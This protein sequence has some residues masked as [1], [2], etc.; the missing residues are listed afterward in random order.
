MASIPYKNLDPEKREIRLLE[1]V[2]EP[3]NTQI[4]YRLHTVSLDDKPYFTALSYVWGDPLVTEN[5]NIDGFQTPVTVN[6]ATALKHV[7]KHWLDI[8]NERDTGRDAVEFRIWAD[9]ICINQLDLPEKSKQVPLMKDIYAQADFIF[10]WLS[11]EDREISVSLEMLEIV[12]SF[13]KL[14]V[15]INSGQ[16]LDIADNDWAKTTHTLNHSIN[17][18]EMV[19]LV[20]TRFGYPSIEE[21]DIFP[22]SSCWTALKK[23]ADLSY[24]SR[25]WILQ[26]LMLPKSLYFVCPS[27]SL[28]HCNAIVAVTGIMETLGAIQR[29]ET[30]EVGALGRSRASVI[31]SKLFL[32][33]WRLNLRQAIHLRGYED[34][35]LYHVL[36][37][38]LFGTI[39]ATNPRDYVYGVL[40]ITNFDIT[41]DY[42]ASIRKV[43]LDYATKLINCWSTLW[44]PP[45][46][47]SG[48][49]FFLSLCA[50][51]VQR[52]G[53]LPTWVPAFNDLRPKGWFMNIRTSS[54]L[55][56]RGVAELCQA[57][58]VRISDASLRVAGVKAQK[59][60]YQY[61]KPLAAD[62]WTKDLLDCFETLLAARSST[63]ITG[64]PLLTVICCTLLQRLACEYNLRR[65]ASLFLYFYKWTPSGKMGEEFRQVMEGLEEM[66]MRDNM[67][68]M[69]SE[70]TPIM[71]ENA[72]CR[73]VGTDDYIG[74]AGGDVQNGD[75]V[76]VLK[77]C[78]SPVVLRPEED[79]YLF[80][81][82]CFMLG[83]MKG[84]VSEM[85]RSKMAE[86]EILEIR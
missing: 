42:H 57:S 7:K 77:D 52:N 62:F 8:Q 15:Y 21:R 2:C 35:C 27:R 80:V 47:T 84:E 28:D 22:P 56:F 23:L 16:Q 76:C 5:I 6:L 41:P 11:S 26:E 33:Q 75:I 78:N 44:Q 61:H 14:L 37:T 83:L 53:D 32:V 74:V 81:S 64:T 38:T 58:E 46:R 40:A 68:A 86:V 12:S 49:L 34:S 59:I 65:I 72:G 45:D 50:A 3:G 10:A 17:W 25:V 43:Y 19:P 31:R 66:E 48:R 39:R 36:S 63:Y 60:T 13:V 70:W 71:C 55:A 69:L 1:V 4:S 73:L 30:H 79:H 9:A 24:W 51:G 54:S 67:E 29:G 20:L 82:P 18:A 85:L